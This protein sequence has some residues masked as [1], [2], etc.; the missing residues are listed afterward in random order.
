[1]F[2]NLLMNKR[3][4]AFSCRLMRRW[5]RPVLR[6]ILLPR[7]I[8]LSLLI[9]MT[10]G[11]H[12]AASQTMLLPERVPGD[13]VITSVIPTA[14]YASDIGLMGA[15]ALSRY[16]E[17][18]LY[19]P[20][21]SLTALRLRASTKA[22]L[23]LRVIYEHTETL[24]KPVRSRWVMNAERHPYDS[25]FGLGNRTPYDSQRWDDEYYFYDV[26][27]IGLSWEGRRT[28]FRPDNS[29]ATLG[30]T[31]YTGIRYE[32]PVKNQD[33]FINDDWP[34]GI[35]GGWTNRLGLGLI[36]ENRD[37]EFAATR[38]NR[39][40]LSGK[41]TP[42]FLLSD[43]PM[44]IVEAD[45]RQFATIPFP[46]IRPVLAMRVAGAHAFGT[47]PYWDMPYLGDERTLRGYPIYR[48]RG[49][50]SLFYNVEL[51]TWLYEHS[52]FEIKFG[53][54][55][56]HDGG[57]VFTGEDRFRDILSDYHR[58][59][60][61]GIALALFSPDFIVRFDAGFSDE[62]MRLYMNIGYM[63]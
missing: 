55:G 54:H 50:A 60:G 7:L 48:F 3:R 52:Y 19:H 46:W 58:T 33:N 38:G 61:G 35:S 9:T 63:F 31:G 24:G 4:Q 14:A 42:P 10:V 59:F 26:M 57:R 32:Q 23:E 29:R 47:V 53:I 17:H 49:D 56:F 34:I 1:M 6:P 44:A 39:F 5:R 40:M 62:M 15:L 8:M 16:R 30:V 13:T 43:Y 25:Y 20:F 18:P 12:P 45:V 28:V 22:Y 51:R 36:W 11:L 37:S 21:K 2:R 41:W 27:R